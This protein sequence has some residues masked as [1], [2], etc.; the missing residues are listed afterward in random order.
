MVTANT[1]TP[2][3][4]TT[5]AAASKVGAAASAV[6]SIMTYIELRERL[7]GCK[8]WGMSVSALILQWSI[9]AEPPKHIRMYHAVA[10]SHELEPTLSLHVLR[11]L[12]CLQP[13]RQQR[14][15]VGHLT[16]CLPS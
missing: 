16:A 14:A 8:E 13:L 1:N 6:S 2:A 10:D 11:C 12:L 4:L 3:A 15:V 9:P 5:A 7:L